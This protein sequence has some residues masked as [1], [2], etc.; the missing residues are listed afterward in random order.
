[1]AGPAMAP[2]PEL[3]NS[4]NRRQSVGSVRPGAFFVPGDAFRLSFLF[5]RSIRQIIR[6]TLYSLGDTQ[7]GAGFVSAPRLSLF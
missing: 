1:M 4:A 3:D 7:D 6:Q 2:L 5:K